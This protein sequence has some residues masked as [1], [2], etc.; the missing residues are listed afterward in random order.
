MNTPR[1]YLVTANTKKEGYPYSKNRVYL[2]TA[3]V[4]MSMLLVGILF[5]SDPT[6][7]LP[8]LLY[9]LLSTIIIT[10]ATFLLKMRLYPLVAGTTSTTEQPHEQTGTSGLTRKMLLIVFCMLVAPILIPLLLAG[11]IGGLVWFALMTSFIL[12]VS[13]SEILYYFSTQ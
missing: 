6:S 8:Y 7:G 11:L 1:V 13:I 5:H 2:S 9:S 3:M 4:L 10:I 12:G